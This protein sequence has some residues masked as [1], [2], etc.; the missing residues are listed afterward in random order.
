MSLL[1]LSRKLTRI[2]FF[3]VCN[4]D[5]VATLIVETVLHDRHL[6]LLVVLPATTLLA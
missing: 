3:F 6:L 2:G 5:T 1:F 4:H